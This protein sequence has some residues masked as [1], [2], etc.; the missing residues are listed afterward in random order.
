MHIEILNSNNIIFKSANF[1]ASLKNT[2][3]TFI[4]SAITEAIF[5]ELSYITLEDE[6]KNE[7]IIPRQ[8]IT[9]SIYKFIG[10]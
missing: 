3:M 10:E 8:L 4:T 7:V 5:N 1:D 2:K 9:G 6:K